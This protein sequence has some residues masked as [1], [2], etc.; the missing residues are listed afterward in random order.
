MIADPLT[1]AMSCDRLSRTLRTGI[2]D[3]KPTE[4]SLYI[5]EKN[6]AVRK[7]AREAK[8]LRA[9]EEPPEA[10]LPASQEEDNEAN[11]AE[12]TPHTEESGEDSEEEY[13]KEIIAEQE[14]E[15]PGSVSYRRPDLPKKPGCWD[16]KQKKFIVAKERKMRFQ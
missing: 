12:T 10:G 9:G 7:K 3:L 14:R 15:I 13:R 1:K 8:S 5:K 6:K 11:V 4:E 2:L 16:S